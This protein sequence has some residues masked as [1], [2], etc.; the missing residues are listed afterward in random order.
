MGVKA[1]DRSV[2]PKHLSLIT[3][4]YCSWRLFKENAMLL[5]QYFSHDRGEFRIPKHWFLP[6]ADKTGR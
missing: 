1:E 3:R 2:E 6:L 4:Q 5:A